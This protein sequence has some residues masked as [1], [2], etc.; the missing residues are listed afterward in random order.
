MKNIDIEKLERK[1]SQRLPDDFFGDVQRNVFK[2]IEAETKPKGKIVK[3]NFWYAAA[4]SLVLLFGLGIFM[5]NL[6]QDV[7]PL[8]VAKKAQSKQYQNQTPQ[9]LAY[10]T[11]E[12]DLKTVEK[13]NFSAPNKKEESKNT[14]NT[15]KVSKTPATTTT[16]EET[17]FDQALAGFSSTELSDLAKGTEQD[18]YLDLYN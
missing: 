12:Q 8:Q 2:K 13:E 5:Q 9:Q 11:L 4:A 1:N 15:A 18:I 3:L 17:H 6:N 16:V 7:S 10:N 14:E